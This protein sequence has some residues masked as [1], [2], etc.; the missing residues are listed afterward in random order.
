MQITEVSA[1]VMGNVRGKYA[2][3][4]MF[5]KHGLVWQKYVSGVIDCF[6]Q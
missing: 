4:V 2:H 6:F 1:R 3:S 5:I